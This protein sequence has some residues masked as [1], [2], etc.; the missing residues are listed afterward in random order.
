MNDVAMAASTVE[1]RV[2]LVSPVSG[3]I[4]AIPENRTFRLPRVYIPKFTRPAEEITRELR[5]NWNLN[6]V[7]VRMVSNNLQPVCAVA[8]VL[9]GKMIQDGGSLRLC[10]IEEIGETDLNSCER[11]NIHNDL[12][13]VG[14]FPG[15][16]SRFGWI[17][18]AQEWIQQS[19]GDHGINFS[20]DFRQYNASDTFAL[21]RFPTHRGPAYWLKATGAPNRHELSVT[22][23]LSKLFPQYL[24]PFV[25][26]RDDWNAWVTEDC[27]AS[28]GGTQDLEILTTA[29]EALADLQLLSL[30]H[31]SRL[32]VAGCMSRRLSSLQV[33]LPEMFAYLEDAMKHQTSTKV[34]PVTSSRLGEIR[35]VVERACGR[36]QELNI[37][38]CLVNGDINLDNILFNDR[39][40]RF[41]DWAEGGI[42]NPFLTLQQI[43][44]HVTSDGQHQEWVPALC[45]AYRTK[46]L[47]LVSGDDI[48]RAFSLMPLV[49]IADYLYGRGHWLESKR[50]EE[51]SFQSFARTLGRCMDRAAAELISKEAL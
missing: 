45:K 41:T 21:I 48:D 26:H 28:L 14:E 13:G 42:G 40:C 49:A 31:I 25:A 12:S 10:C 2:V 20:D 37:P 36:M 17:K 39:Q 22:A 6:T 11:Q 32:E 51:A 35:S 44:Q 8:E 27:G 16:F 18:D 33:K 4:W 5:D 47:S 19:V 46:W 7:I 1:Y 30:E 29:V 50:R 24:P 3:T 23:E 38:D 15:P 9:E 43:I 34:M